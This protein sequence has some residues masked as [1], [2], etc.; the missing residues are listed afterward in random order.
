MMR[1]DAFADLYR[2]AGKDPL[3]CYRSG[4]MVCE[5]IFSG[6]RLMPCGWNTAGYPQNV[7]SNFSTRFDP[8]PLFDA[9]EAFHL[10]LDGTDAALGLEWL[11]VEEQRT[12]AGLTVRVRLRSTLKPVEIAVITLLDGTQVLQRHLELTN[13]GSTGVAVS[14]L[15][16]YAG[17]LEV[18]QASGIQPGL[19]GDALSTCPVE[20]LY[21]LGYM[22]Q[23]TG[24]REGDFAWHALKPDVTAFDGRW[25]RERHRY[26]MAALYSKR[27]GI[28]WL[29]Q[30]AW[31]AGFRFEFDLNAHPEKPLSRLGCAVKLTG[32]EP[33]VVL[34]PG[35]T[36]V[37]P[38][39]HICC[40]H[41]GLDDAVNEMHDHIRRS[42]LTLT[43]GRTCLVGGGMG[44]EHDMSVE[45]SCR[46]ADQLAALGAEVFIVDAG[47]YCP[48]GKEALEWH[49]RAGDWY[50]DPERYPNGI[51]EVREHCRSIGLKFGMWLEAERMGGMSAALKEHPEWVTTHLD[52]T[53]SGGFI[54][55]T[56]PE[57]AAWVESEAAR[58][59]E[60]YQ[61]DLFRID[62]NVGSQEMFTRSAQGECLAAR[63]VQAVYAM[64]KRLKQR[65]PHVI[66]ENCA[67]GGGRCDLGMLEAFDHSWVSDNQIAPRSLAITNGMSMV[68]PPE[69][70]DRLV[71]GMGCHAMGELALQMRNA[72]FGHISLNVLGPRDAAWNPG[73]MAVIQHGVELYKSFVR[74]LL[75]DSRIYHHTPEAFADGKPLV[76]EL[77]AADGS[78]GM[79]GVFA[80]ACTGS[81]DTVIRP[82]GLDFSR[83]WRVTSD[84]S[85][86]SFIM[87]GW[88]LA[89]NGLRIALDVAMCSELMLFEAVE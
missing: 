86:A 40:V 46:F 10:E 71:S 3:L 83:R 59:I 57:A 34:R 20:E 7:L 79:L 36:F 74:P 22:D 89:Q 4:M 60:E 68:L 9:P 63:H 47:W 67:G 49:P 75:P 41:G 77:C 15:A 64:Y 81:C 73:Q 13:T 28:T 52:G 8:Q 27:M 56:N 33:A 72:M 26:P 78:K 58:V 65:F 32:P 39:V 55:M 31:S 14:H 82:R 84:N 85:G 62:Y 70:M 38:A 21:Q 50:P 6:G 61:L 45:T 1:P 37:T 29:M 23:D 48:P 54:D 25:R 88:Q 51:A 43:D 42:V 80:P 17:G 35:E 76:L 16:V 12:D 24:C 53:S 5:E 18:Q 30:L 11:G 19:F 69:R 44:P 2:P 66:F 87:E